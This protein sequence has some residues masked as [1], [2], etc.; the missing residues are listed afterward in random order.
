MNGTER[1]LE[2]M[3]RCQWEVLRLMTT[4]IIGQAAVSYIPKS[5]TQLT[6]LTGPKTAKDPR[7]VSWVGAQTTRSTS[8]LVPLLLGHHPI[9][10][11]TLTRSVK[12][13]IQHTSL[14]GHIQVL[15]LDLLISRRI[16]AHH[17]ILVYILKN[18]EILYSHQQDSEVRLLELKQVRYSIQD[19]PR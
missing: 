8:T 6:T 13:A 14:M 3:T 2:R 4:L 1:H 9:R 15:G 18:E 10:R 16:R 11:C 17:N 19:Q 5:R 12:F 7:G